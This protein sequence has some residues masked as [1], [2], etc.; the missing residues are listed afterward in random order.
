[1]EHDIAT[2]AQ[3]TWGNCELGNTQR[4]K[5]AGAIGERMAVPPGAG[6][7]E[8]M[9]S[10]AMLKGAYRLLNCPAVGPEEWW[11]PHHEATRRAAGRYPT[12]LFIQDW[13][14]L[15]YSHHPKTAGIGPVGA[16]RQ[17]GMLLH[18]VLAYAVEEQQLLG[19]AYGKVIVR[20]EA[21]TSG[22]RKHNGG[23]R[24]LG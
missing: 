10:R 12:V 8:Q 13:T 7:P 5:R 4:T 22:G 21:E 14:T 6:L 2:W 23:R 16:R 17:R 3:A 18:S 20:S 15:D 19:L 24:S 11:R 9:G 1:M